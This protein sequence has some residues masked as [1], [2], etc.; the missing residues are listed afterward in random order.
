MNV[1]DDADR[2]VTRVGV[3]FTEAEHVR[4]SEEAAAHGLTLSKFI[5]ARMTGAKITSKIDATV[6]AELRRQGGLIKHLSQTGKL[7][8]KFA[9]E[10]ALRVFI[11]AI[12]RI[13]V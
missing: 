12:K 4:L 13:G 2:L 3:R 1:V 7:T 10:E 9:A 6:L 8:D 11:E 5:R